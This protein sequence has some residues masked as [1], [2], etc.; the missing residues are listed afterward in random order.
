M[1]WHIVRFQ[2]RHDV[3]DDV[4]RALERDIEALADVIDEVVWLA[5]TRSVDE[6]AVTGL[7]SLFENDDGLAVYRTHPE[8]VPVVER[9]RALCDDIVR[10]DVAAPLP[11]APRT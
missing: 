5:V 1:L 7:L 9:A 8:H 3:A 2:F 6:P 11:T 10:L 4:R